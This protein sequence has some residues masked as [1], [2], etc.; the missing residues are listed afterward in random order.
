MSRQMAAVGLLCM[1]DL[2]RCGALVRGAARFRFGGC[3]FRRY[4]ALTVERVIGTLDLPNHRAILVDIVHVVAIHVRDGS[5]MEEFAAVP[6][7]AVKA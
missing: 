1:R 5:V 3:W 2:H 7:S 4:S 6:M